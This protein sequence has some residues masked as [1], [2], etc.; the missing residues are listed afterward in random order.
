MGKVLILRKIK[1]NSLPSQS[2]E[3]HEN[4][5]STAKKKEQEVV[6]IDI[7]L[8]ILYN[9]MITPCCFVIISVKIPSIPFLWR[10]QFLL[11]CCC[12]PIRRRS[13]RRPS[14]APK[15]GHRNWRQNHC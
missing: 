10:I 7:W 11:A 14:V 15:T 8:I 1:S 13:P 9:M 5:L 6:D 4:N 3:F 12:E 2:A